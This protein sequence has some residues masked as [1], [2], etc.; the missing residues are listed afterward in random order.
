MDYEGFFTEQ[1]DQLHAE[2][3]YRIFANLE[4][5][6]TLPARSSRSARKSGWARVFRALLL[7]VSRYLRPS[8]SAIQP[9]RKR[10]MTPLSPCLH[11]SGERFFPCGGP[12]S[13]MGTK[14]AD[15]ISRN[16]R[17]LWVRSLPVAKVGSRSKTGYVRATGIL[18]RRSFW[19][20]GDI[21]Q[22]LLVPLLLSETTSDSIGGA[23]RRGRALT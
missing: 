4:P 13:A 11:Q 9:D 22:A 7:S 21:P 14:L 10:I 18:A 12:S 23:G 8:C 3:R 19:R 2:G 17:P 1:L 6:K 16:E 20:Q 5:S 15:H